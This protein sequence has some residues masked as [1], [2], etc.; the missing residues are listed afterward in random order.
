M[1]KQGYHKQ[2]M[3]IKQSNIIH[4]HFTS[5]LGKMPEEGYRKQLMIIEHYTQVVHI[6][7]FGEMGGQGYRKHL[8]RIKHFTQAVQFCFGKMRKEGYSKQL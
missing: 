7:F 8:I 5:G 2:L 4:K 3:I 1:E 6:C